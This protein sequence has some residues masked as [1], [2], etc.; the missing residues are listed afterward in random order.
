MITTPH[1]LASQSGLAILRRGG[2]AVDAAIAAG[3]VLSVVYPQM[4]GLGGDAFWLVHDAS[5]RE[6]RALNAS[7]RAARTVSREKFAA[8][9]GIPTRGWLSAITVPGMVSGWGEAYAYSRDVLGTP[10]SWA[11]LL[12]DAVAYAEE[13]V[14]LASSLAQW[15]RED[16]R[17]DAGESRNLQRFAGFRRVFCTADDDI[18]AIGRKLRQPELAATL[19][20]LASEGWR[21]FYEGDIA[22]RIAADMR[23]G[24]GLLTEDDFAAHHADWQEPLHVKYR[25]FSVL[26]CPPNSQGMASLELLSI[27]SQIDVRALGEG[28][29]DYYHV[30]IEATKLAFADRDRYLGDPEFTEIPLTELLSPAHAAA[31]A[32]RI[33]MRRAAASVTPLDPH[34]DTIWLGVVDARGTAVSM[35]QSVY[36]D[37]GSGIVAGDTGVLLQNRGCFFSLDPS[38]PNCLAPGKRPFH[39][40]NPPMLLDGGVPRLVY[41]TMGGEGQPQTQAALVTRIMDFGMMPQEAVCAPRWLYGRS[42]G[43]A[44]NNIRL[45]SRIEASVVEEL[46][47]RGHDVAV[48]TA[49]NDVM[50]HAGAIWRHPETAFLWGAADLR[51][52]GIAAGW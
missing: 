29:A 12:E 3:A 51:G 16:T 36:H 7:G 23:A 18:C 37:F 15:L 8:L 49:F 30:I 42:W 48:T 33:D 26:N 50:G 43:E 38:S 9:G 20:R 17:T 25:N 13:G 21:A 10:L 41:G 1:Y 35:I 11:D 44:V 6:S 45:E 31:Q 14:P 47:R 32:A 2:T 24:G 22:A 46:R 34:G 27:L 4:C 5:R 28:T 40:L 39:T 19:R 52:D